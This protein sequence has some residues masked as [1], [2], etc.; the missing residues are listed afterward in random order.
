MPFRPEDLPLGESMETE[1]GVIIERRCFLKTAASALAVVAVPGAKPLRVGT[2]GADA[3]TVEEFLAEALP[4]ARAVV[5]DPTL[6][7][8]DQ[9]LQA[10]ASHAVRLAEVEQPEFRA[11]EQ[12]EGAF[13]GSNGARP[14]IVL[15]HWRMAPG[16]V[17][18][19][20]AH[21]YGSVV[22]LGLEGAARV[23]NYEVVGKRD[24]DSTDS[25][26]VRQ[27]VSQR[28]T[29][30]ATNLVSLERNYIH[31]FVATEAGARGLDITT[32]LRDRQ[33][34]PYLTLGKPVEG[35]P[36][37]FEGSWTFREN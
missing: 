37:V 22:T 1:P 33:R 11:S 7:R 14:P 3:L 9:Y 2:T 18:H 19:R 24:Y 35:E 29:P 17:I 4:I 28:L 32:R 15:L 36:F 6:A 25:F 26:P 34:T 5:E 16:A 10:L 27:T 31:G 12:G 23:E 8:Q 21:T 30:G 20:H 13:I